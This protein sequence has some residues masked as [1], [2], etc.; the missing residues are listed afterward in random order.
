[1]SSST[2]VKMV[3]FNNDQQYPILGLGTWQTTPELKESEQI[4]IYDA[5]KSAIDIGYLHFDCAAFYNNE[6]SIG[7]AIAEKIKEG[8]VKREDLYITSKLWNNKHNP[9]VVADTLKNSLKLL[10]LDYLDLYL[11]HWPIATSDYPIAKDSEGRL[12]GADDSYLDTWKAME[13]CVRLGLT[14]SI[15][16]SNFNI[17]QVKEILKIALIKP[18]V[19]QVENH[20]YLTQNKLK[21]VCESNGILLTAYGPLGSPYRDANSKVLLDEPFVKQIADKYKKTNAQ[22]LIRFQVLKKKLRICILFIILFLQ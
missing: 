10:G 14:K 6:N 3:K 15:G 16:I 4:E 9:K 18:A 7:K 2:S 5:V 21:E 11:I 17:K 20:P 19:N 22:I 1:M 8:V 12:I 13:K